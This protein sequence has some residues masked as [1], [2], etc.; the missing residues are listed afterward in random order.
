MPWTTDDG[1]R[2]IGEAVIDVAARTLLARGFS[3]LTLRHVADDAGLSL[4]DLH[5]VFHR[6][7]CLVHAIVDCAAA[8]F[9]LPLDAAVTAH[10][11]HERLEDLLVTQLGTVDANRDVYLVAI[12]R[13]LRP[14]DYPVL[15]P[16]LSSGLSRLEHYFVRF[17]D[18][19]ATHVTPEALLQIK[20][21][22]GLTEPVDELQRG[23][24][25]V[26]EEVVGKLINPERWTDDAR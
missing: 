23:L 17:E 19:L 22:H 16:P 10:G 20:T 4:E 25:N 2:A 7:E 3:D 6:K 21:D 5:A 24:D 9:T 8:L 13:L 11:N 18:W 1:S 14:A 15:V 26:V 12:L